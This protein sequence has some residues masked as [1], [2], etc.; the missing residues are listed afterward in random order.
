MFQTITDLIII[1]NKIFI[2]SNN[3]KKKLN[4]EN[5]NFSSL[6]G[7]IYFYFIEKLF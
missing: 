2:K 1:K 6:K 3:N 7:Y 4:Y 5:L